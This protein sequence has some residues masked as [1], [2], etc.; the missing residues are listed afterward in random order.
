MLNEPSAFLT[1]DSP[2]AEQAE[3]QYPPR[4]SIF[5]QIETLVSAVFDIYTVDYDPMPPAVVRYGGRLRVDSEQA[6]AQ[7]DEQFKA[8]D[9]HIAMRTDD[10]GQHVILALKGRVQAPERP[11]WPHVLLFMLTLLSLLFVGAMQAAGNRGSESLFLLDGWPFAVSMMLI[12]GAHEFGHYITARR[13]GLNVSL[14]YFIPF[15]LHV[16]GTLGAFILF[17]EPTPNR[18]VMFDV[19]V[20]GPL[21]GL[22]VALPVL[23]LG[24]MTSEIKPLPQDEDYMIEGD[25]ILYATA[26]YWV[27]GEFLPN[28]DDEDVFVNQVAWAG[29]SGLLLTALNLIPAGQLDGGHIMYTLLGERARQLYWPMVAVFVALS[30]LSSVWWLLTFLFLMFGRFY[31]VPL[32]NVTPLDSRRRRLAYLAFVIFVLIF[33]PLPLRMVTV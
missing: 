26:K 4:D 19:G 22:V 8:L 13:H 1:G 9:C 32:D 2:V 23:L 16:F 3:A 18:K 20:A 33:V 31:A 17:R 29:W 10:Q 14:P 27:F 11:L 5:D 24:L 25:S 6:Y 7:L 21:A 12:L 15:P 30:L 28:D